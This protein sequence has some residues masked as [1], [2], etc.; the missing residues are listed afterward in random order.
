MIGLIADGRKSAAPAR[1]KSKHGTA[2]AERNY[3]Q[4]LSEFYAGHPLPVPQPK[5]TADAVT[6]ATSPRLNSTCRCWKLCSSRWCGTV[7][8]E[9]A[10]TAASPASCA[11]Q[12]ARIVHQR[13]RYGVV[14][15]PPTGLGRVRAIRWL[16]TPGAPFS[17]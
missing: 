15:S 17:L 2:E 4:F 11:S 5:K 14:T 8:L 13:R 12:T 1:S 10:S 6:V 7:W 3:R 16:E 9:P